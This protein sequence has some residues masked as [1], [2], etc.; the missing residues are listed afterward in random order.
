MFLAFVLFLLSAKII[1][2]GF[3]CRLS[4]TLS[5]YGCY[6]FFSLC[7]KCVHWVPS[8]L[9]G[10]EGVPDYNF[11]IL[12]FTLHEMKFWRFLNI[13]A[14]EQERVK[15]GGYIEREKPFVYYCFPTT[16]IQ[17]VF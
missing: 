8:R 14:L 9:F 16:A 1:H 4:E 12:S 11:H 17:T 13:G 6:I 2:L 15:A 3:Q 7:Y 10:V 5:A